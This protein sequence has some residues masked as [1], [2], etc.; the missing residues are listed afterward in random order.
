MSFPGDPCDPFNDTC[1]DGYFCH[2][3][4]FVSDFP[5]EF[6]CREFSPIGD[7]TGA[8]GSKCSHSPDCQSGLKCVSLNDAP[9][10]AC[11]ASTPG[12]K[13][14]VDHCAYEE[15]CGTGMTCD[16]IWWGADLEDYLDGYTGIGAC[17]EP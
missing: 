9:D 13:C 17:T 1:I 15:T 7:E 16:V 11:D 4:D 8:Y 2:V 10:G 5:P 6:R 14:C 12:M 3:E